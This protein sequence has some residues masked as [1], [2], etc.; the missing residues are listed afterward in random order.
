ML[1]TNS[2]AHPHEF[3]GG[4]KQSYAYLVDRD[5]MGKFRANDNSQIVGYFRVSGSGI[6]STPAA[7]VPLQVMAEDDFDI[8]TLTL[9]ID[10]L[11][12]KQHWT[13]PLSGWK[14]VEE[15]P[16][17]TKT[18]IRDHFDD[19]LAEGIPEGRRV[20]MSTSGSSGEPLEFFRD[21]SEGPAEDGPAQRFL[22]RLHGVPHIL[23]CYW[24]LSGR[25]GER[26]TPGAERAL[27]T[28]ATP[29]HAI[30]EQVTTGRGTS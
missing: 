11:G 23:E 25:A 16:V 1:P 27:S 17:L 24:Q 3:F 9:N 26:Q 21:I 2:S 7:V 5:N 14:P 29:A 20:A 22:K 28:Y 6:P 10:R 18:M 13:V 4:G 8:T 15:I 19:L 12:D 30:G